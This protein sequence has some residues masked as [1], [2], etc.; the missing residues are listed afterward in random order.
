MKSAAIIFF[1][2]IIFFSSANDLYGSEKDKNKTYRSPSEINVNFAKRIKQGSNLRVWLSNQ[3][4]LGLQAWDGGA[5]STPDG[6][7]CE[8][9]A[10]SMIEH[11]Y[12]AGPL[13]GVKIDSVIRV[14][15]GY[16]GYD[17]RKE[18]LPEYSHLPREQFWRTSA[19][20]HDFDSLGYN[21]YYYNNHIP[22]NQK[23][24]DDDMDGRVDEDQLD[25]EDNDGDW[26]PVADDVGKDGLPDSTEVS[27]N[28][29]PYDPIN[30]PDPA[31]DNYDPGVRDYCHPTSDGAYPYKNNKDVYTEMNGM[32][33][34]GEPRVDEDYGA[35]SASDLHCSAV[36]TFRKP[37]IVGHYPMGLKLFS[38]SY[39]WNI[40]SSA[41]PIVFLQY[42][43]INIG[44]K[45]WKDAIIGIFADPDLGPVTASGYYMHNCTAYDHETMTGYVYN[46]VDTPSTPLGFTLISSSRPLDSL[47]RYFWWTDFTTPGHIDPGTNDSILYQFLGGWTHP[48][49]P[50]APDLPPS[51]PTDVRFYY[52]FGKY[53]VEPAETLKM[54]FAM[55]SG[56]DVPDMLNNAKRAIRIDNSGGFIMPVAEIRD[57]G[58]GKPVT[59]SWQSVG[60]SPF[61]SVV[62]YRVYHGTAPGIYTDSVSTLGLSLTYSGLA[63]SLHYFAVRAI[64][65]HGNRSAISDELSMIPMVPN[66]FRLYGLQKSINLQWDPNPDPD[67]AGYNIYRSVNSDTMFIKINGDFIAGNIFYD[68]AVTGENEYFYS[69]TAVDR[70]GYES[71]MTGHLHGKLIPP[72]MPGNF[73]LGQGETFVRLNWAPNVEEDLAGYNLYR[74]NEGDIVFTKLNDELLTSA[75]YVD[76]EVDSTYKYYYLEA[77]DQ[78]SATSMPTYTLNGRTERKDAGILL[79]NNR[80]YFPLIDAILNFSRNLLKNYK[81]AEID[82]P[83]YSLTRHSDCLQISP[84][85]SIIFVY[86][87]Q[88]LNLSQQWIYSVPLALKGYLLG[89]GKLFIVGRQLS[90]ASYP[91]WYQ[92]LSDIFRIDKLLEIDTV[93]NFGG[94]AGEKGFPGLSIRTDVTVGNIERFPQIPEEKVLYRLMTTSDDS[95]GDGQPVGIAAADTAM[96]AYYMSFPLY[97]LDSTSAQSLVDYVLNDFGEEPLGVGN[98]DLNLPKE[99]ALHD[100]YPNPFNP[101]TTIMFDLPSEANVTIGVYDLLGREVTRLVDE[102]KGAGSHKVTWEAGNLSTGIYFYRISATDARSQ[103]R[104]VGTKKAILVK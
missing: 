103:I 24:I 90:L 73:V 5:E 15:E 38:K 2:F 51:S 61:G 46:P 76:H 7:G 100:A 69:L 59:I 57:S 35:I 97:Y 64:D 4:T 81:Y 70:D 79:I 25:G 27:C 62:S 30:N 91:Y 67:M 12:G 75:D 77:V 22:V 95:T 28:G 86:E 41:D 60:T 78:T 101:V 43:F 33:D 19:G 9:P 98:P 29:N 31:M 55:V 85:S 52:S 34:H 87:N 82:H 40:G 6:I 11:L 72:A 23:L 53:E 48:G 99:F 49:E 39:A 102:R 3:M 66:N 36:D 26:N 18:I 94:A 50:I 14:S 37:T 84:Y 58:S 20:S 42:D 92:F 16:N 71:G 104:S 96:K 88:R 13:I 47:E 65:E 93:K 56:N 63:S 32:A 54:V 45:P 1:S 10:G 68:T 80:V 8:Y 21:G 17:A 44:K 74:R 83:F 89:G